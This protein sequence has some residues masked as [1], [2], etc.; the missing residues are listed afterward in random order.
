MGRYSCN[1]AIGDAF[2]LYCYLQD[3]TA[4]G[5]LGIPITILLYL[6]AITLATSLLYIYLLTLH[7]NGRMLDCWWRLTSK[8]RSFLIPYDLEISQQQ[9]AYLVNKAE[10][11]RGPD[12]ERRK[13]TIYDY[14]IEADEILRKIENNEALTRNEPSINSTSLNRSSSITRQPEPNIEVQSQVVETGLKE[15]T[16]HTAIYTLHLDGL[17]ELYRQFLRLPDGS[18]VEIF[19]DIATAMLGSPDLKAALIRKQRQME[20]DLDEEIEKLEA[21]K[22]G[23]L[24]KLRLSR[25]DEEEEE[26]DINLDELAAQGETNEA[27][28]REKTYTLRQRKNVPEEEEQ[29]HSTSIV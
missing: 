26:E 1:D 18:I 29:T 4:T 7:N 11:W 19:G 20:D 28:E 16:T 25:I 13:C 6:A 2:K 24:N 23:F 5:G 17:K 10:Q 15:I 21:A 9:L 22:N 14:V 12:G 27:L 8:E 3:T